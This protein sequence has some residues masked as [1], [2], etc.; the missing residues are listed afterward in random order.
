MFLA[1]ALAEQ[2]LGPRCR[3]VVAD[4][5]ADETLAEVL[6]E[7]GELPRLFSPQGCFND[8][9]FT[10]HDVGVVVVAGAI[11]PLR[12]FRNPL[13]L[14][15]PVPGLPLLLVLFAGKLLPS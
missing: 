10:L 6:H 14:K 11:L 3:I 9:V 13:P 4:V 7:L 1:T 15:E 5:E 2:E 12:R 8:E